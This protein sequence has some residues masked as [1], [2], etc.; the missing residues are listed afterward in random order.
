MIYYGTEAGMWGGD[1]PDDRK[2]MLWPEMQFA[3]ESRHPLKSKKRADDLN[4][5]DRELYNFYKKIIHIRHQ[6]SMLATGDFEVL[7]QVASESVFAFTRTDKNG[8]AVMLF[9]KAEQEQTV[10]LDLGSAYT[11]AWTGE[12]VKQANTPVN[13]KIP[14]R[15]FRILLTK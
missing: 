12:Q 13:I 9:N 4:I 3:N 1:D 2:P 15:G 11:D 10:D 5:F 7:K 14:A 6:Y 8:K